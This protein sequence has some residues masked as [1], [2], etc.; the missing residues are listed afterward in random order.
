MV[1]PVHASDERNAQASAT[2]LECRVVDVEAHEQVAVRGGQGRLFD[3]DDTRL[4]RPGAL[5]RSV[6]GDEAHRGGGR[7]QGLRPRQ[8]RRVLCQHHDRGA[9]RG[10]GQD[11]LD[12]GDSIGAARAPRPWRPSAM[13]P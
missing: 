12:E 1:A 3:F 6:A 11:A 2:V 13:P 9:R 8:V 10:V 5:N 4:I 7:E